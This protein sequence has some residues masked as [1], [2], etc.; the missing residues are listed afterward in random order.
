MKNDLASKALEHQFPVNRAFFSPDGSY[1]VSSA[2]RGAR[3]WDTTSII[4]A[5]SAYSRPPKDHDKF[6]FAV[7]SSPDGKYFVSGSLGATK[8]WDITG[9]R[10]K[11]LMG[12]SNHVLSVAW[13]MDGKYILSGSGDCTIKLWD[14]S[15]GACLKTLNHN[16]RVHRVAFSPDG[17]YTASW[18]SV[19]RT[20]KLWDASSGA[21]LATFEDES[22]NHTIYHHAD[23]GTLSWDM[24]S[25][26]MSSYT[27]EKPL[28]YIYALNGVGRR[29]VTW[30]GLNVLWLPHEYRPSHAPNAIVTA[31]RSGRLLLLRFSDHKSPLDGYL[32][33]PPF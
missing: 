2:D 7:S 3:L 12:H 20:S 9:T 30:N 13:S 18:S 28:P 27:H 29:W 4:H 11:T 10:V 6:F 24:M 32:C 31:C 19:D 16:S 14:A 26:I 8:L 5:N 22:R 23:H 15:T 33:T 1:I 25:T 21:C 17:K